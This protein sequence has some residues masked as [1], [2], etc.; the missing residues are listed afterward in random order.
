MSIIPSW[1]EP[2]IGIKFVD[3]GDDFSG[4]HCWGLVRLIYRR[5]CKIELPRY[6]GILAGNRD[7]ILDAVQGAIDAREWLPAV[8]AWQPFDVVLMSDYW[9]GSDGALRKGNGHIGIAVSARDLL[10]VKTGIDVSCV[11]KDDM[12][13][14]KRIVGAYRF[15]ALPA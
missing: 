3:E 12:T 6:A 14:K 8:G 5:E 2:Y 7:G 15:N 1:V 9:R 11:G 13:I 4:C 10:H